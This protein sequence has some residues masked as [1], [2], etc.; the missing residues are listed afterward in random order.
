MKEMLRRRHL[1]LRAKVGLLTA[2]VLACAMV[3]F[4][5]ILYAS[6]GRVLIDNT[7]QSLRSSAYGGIAGPVNHPGRA[8]EGGALPLPAAPP[9]TASTN[10]ETPPT[11]PPGFDATHSLSELASMLTN[12]DTAARTTDS[13][14]T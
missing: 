9:A 11:S 1:S 10:Q 14:G 6:I 7:A 13:T 8:R 5:D 12:R 2:S 3:L 4:G